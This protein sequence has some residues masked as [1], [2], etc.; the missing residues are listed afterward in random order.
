MAVRSA[1]RLLLLIS[2]AV[3]LILTVSYLRP[4][5][6]LSPEVRAPGHLPLIPDDLHHDADKNKDENKDQKQEEA[7]SSNGGGGQIS[8]QLLNGAVVMPHLGN[9]T[10]K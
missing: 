8:D 2:L 4:A 6:P 5:S 1:S 9:E 3:F 7:T 10:A